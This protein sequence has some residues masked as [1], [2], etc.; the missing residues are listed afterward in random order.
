[1]IAFIFIASI[2]IVLASVTTASP[3][4]SIKQFSPRPSD[5]I[6][7]APMP[8]HATLPSSVRFRGAGGIRGGRIRG[9]RGKSSSASK[10]GASSGWYSKSFR[11]C[12]RFGD[13]KDR[14]KCHK[15]KAII[16]VSIVGTILGIFVISVIVYFSWNC[17]YRNN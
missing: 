15:E 1:M 4:R 7:A 14:K 13:E 3:L 9:G 16:T 8:R 12:N 5:G 17:F 2:F 6:R 11:K 10:G